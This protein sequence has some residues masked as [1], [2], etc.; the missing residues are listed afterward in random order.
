M[1]LSV[2]LP[3]D[4]IALLDEIAEETGAPSRSAVLRQ[5]IEA[6]RESRLARA[7][8]LA[9]DEWEASGDAAAWAMTETDGAVDE[10]W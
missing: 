10:A 6:L 1:K 9:A 8:E 2:S 3:E 7:Y 5:A 4:D